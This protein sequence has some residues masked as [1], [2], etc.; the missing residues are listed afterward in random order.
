M[1][2]LFFYFWKTKVVTIEE[3]FFENVY[4]DVE[5]TSCCGYGPITN[6]KHC[7]NCGRKIIRQAK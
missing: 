4:C 3:L 1:K 5:K 6:E 2:K 7:P